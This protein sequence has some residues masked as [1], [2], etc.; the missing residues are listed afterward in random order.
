M[1]LNEN[2]IPRESVLVARSA[3]TEIELGTNTSVMFDIAPVNAGSFTATQLNQACDQ[4]E[5]ALGEDRVTI[6]PPCQGGSDR[7]EIV[8]MEDR[9][10]INLVQVKSMLMMALGDI[11]QAKVIGG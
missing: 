7:F 10:K 9:V 3:F 11:L 2:G 5:K 1:C 6:I 8:G 4:V